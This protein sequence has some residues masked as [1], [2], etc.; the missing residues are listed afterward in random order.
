MYPDSAF[1]TPAMRLKTASIHQKQ[2]PP[3]TAV[4]SLAM[5]IRYLE[6]LQVSKFQLSDFDVILTRSGA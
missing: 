1:F 4:S 3:N 2:P 6:R 5:L